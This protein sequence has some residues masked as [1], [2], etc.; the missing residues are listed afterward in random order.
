[1]PVHVGYMCLRPAESG[2][3]TPLKAGTHSTCIGGRHPM[4][5]RVPGRTHGSERIVVLF[6]FALLHFMPI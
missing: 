3:W 5:Y 1:M 4:G 2:L 6:V